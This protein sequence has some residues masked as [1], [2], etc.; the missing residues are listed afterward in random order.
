MSNEVQ[1]QFTDAIFSLV[2]AFTKQ[3]ETSMP[4]KQAKAIV[5]QYLQGLATELTRH[6]KDKK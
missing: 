2:V 6:E 3:L 1:T 5:A 4:Q